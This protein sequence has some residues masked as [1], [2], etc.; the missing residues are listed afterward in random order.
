MLCKAVIRE[1]SNYLEGE[2]DAALVRELEL[3]LQHC[4]N[5]R[6]VVDTT[7]KTIEIYCNTEP[8][9]LPPEVQARLHQA[10]ER[11]LRGRT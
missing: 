3:H 10:L 1:L 6:I 5:C 4:E 11:R 2:L 9:S 7:R 8:A